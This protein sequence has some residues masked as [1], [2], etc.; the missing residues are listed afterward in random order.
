M[1]GSKYCL[2]TGCGNGGIGNALAREFVAKGYHVIATVLPGEYRDHLLNQSDI[3]V[4]DLD[5]TDESMVRGFSNTV[6]KITNGRLDILVNNAGIVYTMPAVDTDIAHAKRLFDVNFFGPLSM[7]HH[8]HRQIV[9]AKGLI[10][11]VGSIASVSPYVYGSVYNASKAALVHFMDTL[12][13][14]M[15][16]FDVR[17]MNVIS[18]EINTTILRHDKER[19]LPERS[20]FYDTMNED[21]K[22]H[23]RR[24][25]GSS[26]PSEYAKAVVKQA[27]KRNPKR[28]FWYG[29]NTTTVWAL[30]TFF[31]QWVWEPVF[32]GMFNLKK[33]RG[34]PKGGRV[35]VIIEQPKV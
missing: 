4:F 32:G 25:P 20:I 21:Y 30:R 8:F 22:A 14:E 1:A 6:A 2:I 28:W 31:G 5:V 17:V 24:N 33:V 23:C 15:R 19:S 35:E 10:V 3:S 16:Y 18:G 29:S 12:R 34:Q 13:V 7:V 9:A 26:L 27:M 11:N